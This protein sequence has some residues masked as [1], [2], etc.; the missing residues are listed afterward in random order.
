MS[1]SVAKVKWFDSAKGYGFLL[2]ESG[3]EIFVHH[4][5]IVMDGYRTLLPD[6]A[7][8]F[9]LYET[10]KGLQAKNVTPIK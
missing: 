8:E 1:K 10:E 6:Q 2:P 4:T 3:K 7:V 5:Q 9:E